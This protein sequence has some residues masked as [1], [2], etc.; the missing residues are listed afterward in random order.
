[1][2]E[3]R[4][5]AVGR[6]VALYRYP[7]KSMAAEPLSAAEVGW[8]GIVGDRRWAFVREGLERNGFPWLTIRQVPR[9]AM[10]KSRLVYPDLPEKS[11]TTVTTPS[12]T[13][14]DVLDPALATEL[15]HG[16]RVIRQSRGVFDA[17][18]LSLISTQTLAA[19]EASVGFEI[20]RRRFR[21]N[22]I[23]DCPGS[24]RFPEDEWIGLTVRLGAMRM[25]I[26]KRDKRCIVT[27]VDPDTGE[28]SPAV[29]RTITELR[30]QFLGVYGSTVDPGIISLGDQVVL[31]DV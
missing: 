21:P 3:T 11:D 29:L 16:A 17:L 1:V 31:G 5:Q 6:V 22:I 9:M 7:V 18:P 23:V 13:E 28:R 30:Q 10:Y 25:R 12:G 19:L 8:N 15:G 14:M 2:K 26:D 27:N 24:S 4:E 20:E